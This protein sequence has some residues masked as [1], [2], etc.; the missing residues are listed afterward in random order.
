[1][2]YRYRGSSGELRVASYESCELRVKSEEP[3]R[4]NYLPFG[5]PKE[6]EQVDDALASVM[7]RFGGSDAVRAAEMMDRWTSF[8]GEW[9]AR[10][11]PIAVREGVLTVEVDTG[12]DAT[13]IRYDEGAIRAAIQREFGADL[14][15]SIKVRVSRRRNR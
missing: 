7:E 2:R 1:M 4:A 6:P 5:N 12:G 8:A 11:H 3:K 15:Q 10:A 13:L 9:G 14:V